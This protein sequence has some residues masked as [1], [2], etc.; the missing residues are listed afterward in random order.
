MRVLGKGQRIAL[1]ALAIVGTAV[2][3]AAPGSPA[4]AADGPMIAVATTPTLGCT[5]IN[6]EDPTLE[7]FNSA[8]Y[9]PGAPFPDFSKPACGT[10]LAVGSRVFGPSATPGMFYDGR[11]TPSDPYFV[12]PKPESFTPLSQSKVTGAG[13]ISNPYRIV[14]RV[15]AGD[16]GVQVVQ[17]DTWSSTTEIVKTRID[18]F[19]RNRSGRRTVLYRVGDCQ[20]GTFSSYGW[21]RPGKAACVAA[22]LDGL[23]RDI[24]R[25]VP[26]PAIVQ[27][28]GVGATGAVGQHG[29]IGLG[30][31]IEPALITGGE[32]DGTCDACD[33]NTPTD[34]S[35][36]LSWPVN[37]P[38]RSS[39]TTRTTT[40]VSTGASRAA[41]Q[42]TGEIDSSAPN[43]VAV[44]L[45]ASPFGGVP[46]Q[47]IR[48]L[49]DG[50]QVCSAVTDADGRVTCDVS[51]VL[52]TVDPAAARLAS[53]MSVEVMYDG[54]LDLAPSSTAISLSDVL[55][56]PGALP[57]PATCLP[58]AAR[59]EN[60]T[61][62]GSVPGAASMVVKTSG[63]SCPT[64]RYAIET[65]DGT[66]LAYVP[67]NGTDTLT[68]DLPTFLFDRFVAV[69]FRQPS[70]EL[71]NSGMSA[72]SPG[73]PI[74]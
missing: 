48:F 71:F 66:V 12:G 53:S 7:F 49:R 24:A 16:T 27:F 59:P 73:K 65:T 3:S 5:I 32:F 30:D 18:V 4:A 21:V 47:A 55:A 44:Q 46:D 52:G 33:A 31:A 10:F 63:P 36:G 57:V 60:F 26:G 2:V 41:T 42:L 19:N 29:M 17:T 45:Q 23:D 54:N 51:Q 35:I 13:S 68:F 9:T 58:P 64:V 8:P 40:T 34:R 61:V 1:A 15:A 70:V 25:R 28:A 72:V 39:R 67:G 74:G 38:G 14:T 50:A 69:R 43:R 37:V 20:E 62:G 6:L 22:A 56:D 11:F